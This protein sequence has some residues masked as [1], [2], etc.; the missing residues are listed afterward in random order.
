MKCFL[1]PD[2]GRIDEPLQLHMDGLEA[3]ETVTIKLS[4]DNENWGYWSATTAAK[5]DENGKLIIAGDSPNLFSKLFWELRPVE[6]QSPTSFPGSNTEAITFYID[7]ETTKSNRKESRTITRLFKEDYVKQ[8]EVSFEEC[9]GTY[10]YPYKKRKLSTIVLLSNAFGISNH[11]LAALLASHGYGIL[12]LN[13]Q[14]SSERPDRVTGVPLETVNAAVHWLKNHPTADSQ[15]TVLFG[16]SKGAELALVAAS[17]NK[18]V[19]GIIAISPTNVVFQEPSGQKR[20]TSWTKD[21]K[22]LPYVP[23]TFSFNNLWKSWLSKLSRKQA[24]PSPVSYEKSLAS[25]EKKG[26]TEA[27]IPVENIKGP[28]LLI[29]GKEDMIWP[30]S[31]MADRIMERLKL[32]SFPYDM[33]HLSYSKAGH[34]LV[35]PYLPI[36]SPYEAGIFYGGDPNENAVYGEEAWKATLAFLNTHFPPARITMETIPFQLVKN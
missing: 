17:H 24:A 27:I 21:G 11:Q 10:Y 4:M 28:V 23:F 3:G 36:P 14:T 16:C 30:S 1:Y 22:D 13:T 32:N 33:K 26:K 9:T 35:Q 34:I 5:A 15:K 20:T 31:S 6:Q 19:T 18:N 7:M 8:E 12:A 29:S 25:Y 2:I